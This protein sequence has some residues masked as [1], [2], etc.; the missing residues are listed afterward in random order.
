MFPSFEEGYVCC[1]YYT[2]HQIIFM[3]VFEIAV[4]GMH[5]KPFADCMFPQ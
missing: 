3:L 4:E 1:F 2:L 5:L